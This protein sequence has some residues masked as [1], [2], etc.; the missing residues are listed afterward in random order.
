MRRVLSI[1]LGVVLLAACGGKD[2]GLKL[3]TKPVT[4]GAI[5][6]KITASG[7]LSPLVTV[8]VGSQVSGRVAELHADFNTA[9]KKGELIARIDPRL[10]DAAVEQAQAS[11]AMARGN[12]TKAKAQAE[13]AA[14]QAERNHKL[15]QDRLI[16]Q[17]D[18]DTTDT[19]LAVTKAGV[20][21]A[22]AAVVQAQAALHQAELN[23][24]YT[25]IVSP[26]D[27]TVISRS[28]DVGQ[29]VAA[30]LSSPVL[31]Q[32][33]QDLRRMQVDTSVA[34]ADV[35]RL[36]AGMPA[37]FTVDAYPGETFQGTIREI[38]NAPQ[39]VQNVVTY[40]AVIDVDNPDLKL[41]PG[42]TANVTVTYANRD[43]VL[44]VPNTA[45]RFRPLPEMTGKGGPAKLGP[46]ERQ[47]WVQ[48]APG[49]AE[50]VTLQVGVS[51]GLVSEVVRG[52]LKDGDEVVIE[53]ISGKKSGGPGS[54]GRVF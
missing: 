43:D 28:V 39:T 6:A 31:F 42:M 38:R 1:S 7:T 22:Q 50:P 46:A 5:E 25:N 9:V 47:V 36:T 26:I 17:S 48:R 37:R 27:G 29:T 23:L 3:Q 33:A 11:L 49:K 21:A 10:F 14:R 53:A 52:D 34:E 8:Q 15:V 24:F 4:R 51:D 30:S 20:E 44:R 40:D 16:S 32:I 41:K 13:D 18:A 12:L 54:F 45:L 2:E 35:G 19:N